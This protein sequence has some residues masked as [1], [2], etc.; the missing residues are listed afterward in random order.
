MGTPVLRARYPFQRPPR[1][2]DRTAAAA[3]GPNAPLDGAR[4]RPQRSPPRTTRLGAHARR[5]VLEETS[6]GRGHDLA[7]Y[8]TERIA[9]REARGVWA[10]VQPAEMYA[11][12]VTEKPLIRTRI[13]R[14]II[15]ASARFLFRTFPSRPH[16]VFSGSARPQDRYAFRRATAP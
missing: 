16:Y 7:R 10:A 15:R 14:R 4:Q 1:G 11:K 6:G 9:R 2:P 12:P 3:K 13:S 5:W 8:L